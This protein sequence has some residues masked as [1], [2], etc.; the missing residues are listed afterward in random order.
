MH[1]YMSCNCIVCGVVHDVED[2]CY[3]AKKWWHKILAF[4]KGERWM[5][6]RY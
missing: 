3:N 1:S 6:R 5:N 2:S 4:L